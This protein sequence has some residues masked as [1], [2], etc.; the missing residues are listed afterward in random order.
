MDKKI[1]REGT[2]YI[3]QISNLPEPFPGATYISDKSFHIIESS[4]GS[5]QIDLRRL[6]MMKTFY[7]LSVINF[8]NI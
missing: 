1:N 6:E 5:I 2:T 4:D 7:T 8:I 3:P